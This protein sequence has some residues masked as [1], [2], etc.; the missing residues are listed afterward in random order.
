M[1]QYTE[2]LSCRRKILLNYFGEFIENDCG[3]CDVCKNPPAFFDGTILSQKILSGIF[4]LKE[5]EAIGTLV[6]FLRGSQNSTIY[7]KGYY[8]LKTYGIA[9]D[10]AWRDLQ[11]YVVQLINLGYCEVAFHENNAL[12]LSELSKKV[13]FEGEKVRLTKVIEKQVAKAKLKT[14]RTKKST[15]DLF[16]RLRLLR[17]SIAKESNIPAYLVFNDATLKQMERERPMTDEEFLAIDGVGRK[18]FEDF[19][20]AFIKE[21]IAFQKEKTILRTKKTVQ[22]K[23]DTFKETL[24]LIKNGFSAED[25]AVQ[26]KLSL[27]TIQ[28]HYLK[29]YQNG[30]AIDLNEFVSHKEVEKVAEAKEQLTNSKSLRDYFE[31]FEEQMPYGVI[32]FAMAILE[33]E[34]G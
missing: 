32:K 27:A 11:Q 23:S 25:I 19:G 24:V 28:S 12:K 3:N 22:K 31:F 14:K 21:I 4:R 26:R 5:Q 34:K 2:A 9:K 18:K 30:E 10:V 13:L 8:Q 6:D 33:K 1:Q 15:T 17:L 7:Q 20:Y 16:E 29:L